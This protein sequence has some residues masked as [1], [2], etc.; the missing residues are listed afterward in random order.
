MSLDKFVKPGK[1]QD[2]AKEPEKPVAK[3]AAVEAEKPQKPARKEPAKKAPARKKAKPAPVE[4]DV[5]DAEGQPHADTSVD[6]ESVEDAVAEAAAP[7][8]SAL[9]AMGLVK[10]ALACPACKYKKELLVAGEPKPHQ[11]LCKKC[12]GQMKSSKKA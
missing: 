10:F 1:K 11:L 9:K 7:R 8:E 12:G 6:G 3:P 4:D 5:D 2:G